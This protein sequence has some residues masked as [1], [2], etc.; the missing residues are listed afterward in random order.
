[1]YPYQNLWIFCNEEQPIGELKRDTMECVLADDFGKWH[2]KGISLFQSSF[3]VHSVY[4]FPYAGQYTFS[5]K[6][7][8]RDHE[9]KGIQEIGLRVEK[10][11]Q[12]AF[13]T[14]SIQTKEDK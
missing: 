10:A 12:S 4:K 9:L 6:Q 13:P 5:F 1:M 2:G 11:N 8:M 7:G 14:G 3:P